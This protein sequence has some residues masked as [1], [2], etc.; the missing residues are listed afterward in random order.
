MKLK[1]RLRNSVACL[2]LIAV[3][4]CAQLAANARVLASSPTGAGTQS[5][6]TTLDALQAIKQA[7]SVAQIETAEQ[8][9]L[10]QYNITISFQ[11]PNFAQENGVNDLCNDITDADF[12]KTQFLA[13]MF[14]EEWSKYP[15]QWTE[16]FSTTNVYFVQ[17]FE[18]PIGAGNSE[19]PVAAYPGVG[20]GGPAY[21]IDQAVYATGESYMREVI[22]HEYY[23]FIEYQSFGQY[24]APDSTWTNANPNGFTYGN[25]GASCYEG[26]TSCQLGTHPENGFVTGY[27]QTALAED[28]AETYAYMFDDVTNESLQTWLQTDSNLAV[29]VNDLKAFMTS[30]DSGMDSNY[31]Q[32]IHD[33]GIQYNGE[34]GNLYGDV[35]TDGDN[36]TTTIPANQDY[37]VVNWDAELKGGGVYTLIVDGK[38]GDVFLAD[39]VI[40]GTG[41]VG[42]LQIFS[43]GT[44]APGHSPG[45]LSSNDLTLNGTYQAQIGGTTACTGFDQTQVTGTVDVTGSTLTPSLYG[46]FVPSVGQSYEIISNDGSDPVT[47]TFANAANNTIT[48]DGVTYSVNYAGGDGNDVVLTVTNVDASTAQAASNA[49][50][51]KTPNTGFQ[52]VSANPLASMGLTVLACLGLLFAAGRVRSA[53]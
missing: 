50:I 38:L 39:G 32:A 41:S 30:I 8:S 18:R 35:V 12:A 17:G 7:T 23:H 24:G 44:L 31:L 51:P 33:Y 3:L 43:T 42:A 13:S 48:A 37:S 27:A 47:G 5:S 1:Y 28:K 6:S 36:V 29:K 52:L 16:H 4:V 25:G 40:E 45:C 10:D 11:C 15:P 19:T 14:T 53:Q 26:D 49:T 22:H 9:F 46:G 2:V 21:S 20:L 34:I